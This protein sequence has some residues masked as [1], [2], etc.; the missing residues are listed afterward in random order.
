[1]HPQTDELV[2]RFSKTLKSLLRKLVNKE[3]RDWD[4]HLPYTLFA[5]HEVPQDSTGFSPFEVLYG[6]EV[7]GLLDVLKEVWEANKKSEESVASYILLVHE[8]MEETSELV[9]E[10]VRA[11][12]MCQK[13]WYDQTARERELQPDKE[14][15]VLFPTNS[16]KLLAQWQGP[17]H[18]LQRVS[19]VNYEVLMPD[20]WKRKKVFHVNMF[21]KWFPPVGS[22]F[23]ATEDTD[24]E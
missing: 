1:M 3:G 12:Q 2:E 11:A 5:Y 21:K 22:S 9:K 6:R 19:K 24:G 14:V 16:N 4:R 10:N 17:Y 20:K 15:F 23:W 18:I 7:T 8:W 13:K